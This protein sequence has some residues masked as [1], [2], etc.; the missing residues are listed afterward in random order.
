MSTLAEYFGVAY[1]INLPERTDRLRWAKK[2]LARV[3]WNTGLT[4][5][6]VL[7]ARRFA[8]RAGFPNAGVRGAFHSHLECMRRANLQQ[9]RGVLILEDDIAFCS[10]L[11]RLTP[12]IISQLEAREW[13]FV[14]FG[15][16]RTGEISNASSTTIP[17]EIRFE[18][19]T[20]EIQGLHFYGV[21]GRILSKVIAHLERVADGVEGDQEAGPM[22]V[23]G[24]LNIFR[25]NNPDVRTLIAHP[26]LGWQRPSRSDITPGKLDSFR[27]LRPFATGFRNLKHVANLWRW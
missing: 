10:S 17:R 9:R 27:L 7:P 24:A 22:P 25:R 26:K 12:S 18:A 13:D 23:D 5:V 16:N 21:S 3:G 14:Y 19:W 1:L 2:E 11:G 20:E 4:G 15:H 8:Q 6:D